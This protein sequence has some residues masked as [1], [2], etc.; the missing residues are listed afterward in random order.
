MWRPPCSPASLGSPHKSL[1]GGVMARL[2]HSLVAVCCVTL[3]WTSGGIAQDLGGGRGPRPVEGG[4]IDLA[5]LTQRADLVVNGFVTARK[6]AWVG[7][8]VYSLYDV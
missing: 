5:Q 8:V 4:P 3:F 7:R 6:A 2:F 1:L